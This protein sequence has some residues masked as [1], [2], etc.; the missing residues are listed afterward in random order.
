[1]SIAPVSL[2]LSNNDVTVAYHS[3]KIGSIFSTPDFAGLSPNGTIVRIKFADGST[4]CAVKHSVPDYENQTE[5]TVW[6]VA[7][8]GTMTSSSLLTLGTIIVIWLPQD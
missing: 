1:M 4:G 6:S 3:V 8:A 5:Q 7:G 2:R